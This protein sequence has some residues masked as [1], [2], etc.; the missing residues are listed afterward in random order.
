MNTTGHGNVS[1][2]IFAA[3]LDRD[4][5]AGYYKAVR[6]LR[7]ENKGSKEQIHDRE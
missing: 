6:S 1:G 2:G 3:E 4:E 5:K 7:P